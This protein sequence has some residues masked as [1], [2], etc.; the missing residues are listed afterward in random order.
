[1]LRPPQANQGHRGKQQ[2]GERRNPRCVV[3]IFSTKPGLLGTNR[4]VDESTPQNEVPLAVVGI[5][6]CKVTA[7]NG[8]IRIGDLLVTSST[9]GHA[10]TV[11]GCLVQW[12]ERHW[13]HC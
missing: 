9:T 5:V 8:A 4:K 7:E 2:P 13:S 1:M 6:P 10:R 11:A 12:S 3:H